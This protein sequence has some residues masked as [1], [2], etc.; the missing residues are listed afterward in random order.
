MKSEKTYIVERQMRET[1]QLFQESDGAVAKHVS[2]S[3][4]I[5]CVLNGMR[6]AVRFGAIENA[7]YT[8]SHFGRA[9]ISFFL[10][11]HSLQEAKSTPCGHMGC[12]TSSAL[13][14][15]YEQIKGDGEKGEK[16]E[17]ERRASCIWRLFCLLSLVL[18]L[19]VF[20]MSVLLHAPGLLGAYGHSAQ[21]FLHETS[22]RAGY[23][24]E[25]ITVRAIAR[26]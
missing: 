22:E 14:A 17:N 18:L 9:F 2:I 21:R 25:N 7:T 13:G 16:I 4:N 10:C 11:S 6:P 20:T 19:T 24:L 8:R 15:E 26:V 3:M 23:P 12:C 1:S 5:D